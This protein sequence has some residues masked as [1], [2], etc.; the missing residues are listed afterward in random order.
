MRVAQGLKF[1]AFVSKVH[2]NLSAFFLAAS[3]MEQLVNSLHSD[4]ASFQLSVVHGAPGTSAQFISYFEISWPIGEGE[5]GVSLSHIRGHALYGVKVCV[6]YFRTP[7]VRTASSLRARIHFGELL[8]HL[9]GEQTPTF[10][11]T[12]WTRRLQLPTQRNSNKIVT[13]RAGYFRS[14]AGVSGH[15]RKMEIIYNSI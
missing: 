4:R 12:K 2:K 14:R 8:I 9:G 10:V 13:L 6:G 11:D 3:L 15:V 5:R 1:L 7:K